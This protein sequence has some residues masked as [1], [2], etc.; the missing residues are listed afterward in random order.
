M[1]S[2]SQLG[3]TIANNIGGFALAVQKSVG[4]LPAPTVF[5]AKSCF[6]ADL[7]FSYVFMLFS[8]QV[9]AWGCRE[10]VKD[11]GNTSAA[12]SHFHTYEQESPVCQFANSHSWK[13]FSQFPG[14]EGMSS[15][16]GT[17][18]KPLFFR[19]CGPKVAC[20]FCSNYL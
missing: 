12:L 15:P 20:T 13:H 18:S 17:F 11:E 5:I 3:Q 10:T 4:L 6:T 1:A 16:R 8:F 9:K 2:F 7:S 19:R 14:E